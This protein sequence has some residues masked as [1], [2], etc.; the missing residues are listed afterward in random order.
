M[1]VEDPHVQFQSMPFPR[2]KV[3]EVVRGCNLHSARSELAVDQDRITHNWNGPSCEWKLD[4]FADEMPIAIGSSGC[5]A[6]A[7]SPNMVSG[8]VVA[9]SRCWVG[10]V[11]PE[12][13]ESYRAFR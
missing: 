7:V 8:R 3:V 13:N 12:D 5:T 9:T 11:R 2:F 6:T 4:P 1:D 10:V